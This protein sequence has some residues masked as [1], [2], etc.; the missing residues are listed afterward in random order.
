ME[1]SSDG[2]DETLLLPDQ[3]T[4]PAKPPITALSHLFSQYFW[5]LSLLS[6]LV[7][8]FGLPTKSSS[9]PVKSAPLYLPWNSSEKPIVFGHLTDPHINSLLP[10]STLRFERAL[11]TYVNLSVSTLLITGD[12]VDNWGS[13]TKERYGHQYEPDFR[14][15][16]RIL[17]EYQ[18]QLGNIVD[19]LGNHDEFG[20]FRFESTQHHALRYV[21]FFQKHT[22]VSIE[23]FWA[24]AHFFDGFYLILL[25]PFRFPTPHA[26]FDMWSRPTRELLDA[27]ESVILEVQTNITAQWATTRPPSV[28]FACHYPVGTWV[29]DTVQSSSGR[30]FTDLITTCNASLFLSGHLHPEK[31]LYLHHNGL[32]EA[33][34]ADLAQHDSLAIV[35]ID[36]GRQIHHSFPLGSPPSVLLTHPVPARLLSSNIP[37]VENSTEIRVI[38]RQPNLT[39]AVRGVVE[40]RLLMVKDLENGWFLYSHPLSDIPAG[41]HTLEFYGDWTFDVDFFVGPWLPAFKEPVFSEQNHLWSAEFGVYLILFLNL[42]L[43]F[44]CNRLPLFFGPR[45]RIRMLPRWLR[46]LLFASYLA[47]LFLPISLLEIEGNIGFNFW[48]GYFA[49]GTFFYDVWGQLLTFEYQI[50]IVLGASLFASALAVSRPWHAFFFADAAF[51]AVSWIA[52]FRDAKYAITESAGTLFACTSPLFV[53]VPVLLYGVLIAWRIFAGP[54]FFRR[55]TG[56]AREKTEKVD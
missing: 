44:P 42:I 13:Q 28:F 27:I 21:N 53:G 18:S 55:P 34:G 35:T 37:F 10:E 47:P 38:A 29:H 45:N 51:A 46:N 14:E 50:G 48:Y 11:V 23:N 33:V 17:A 3:E 41:F 9:G 25:N 8:R 36:N 20:L 2:K 19:I 49:G 40:G 32:L 56:T 22:P 26:R 1:S 7:I 15:Y 30:T 6:I 43:L 16:S 31:P 12:L 54:K 4:D 5:L 24:S 52:A 39:I